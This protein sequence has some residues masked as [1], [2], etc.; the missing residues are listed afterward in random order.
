MKSKIKKS[1]YLRTAMVALAL[2]LPL[3]SL[4]PLGSLW[5][6]QKGYLLYWIVGALIISGSSFLLELWLV[7]GSRGTELMPISADAQPSSWTPRESAAWS[8]V[9]A[10]ATTTDPTLLGSR[11]AIL[12]LGLRTIE[13]V[14]RSIHPEADD[15]L[16]RF[17]VPEVLALIERV[18]RDLRP[19]IADNIPLGDQLTVGQVIRVYRWRGALDVAEKAY[20]LWRIVRLLNPVTAVAN[21]AR[22][23]LSKKL[24]TGV[25]DQVAQRLV[26]GYV[27][28]IGRA[29]IDL[30]GGR[31]RVSAND[32]AEHVTPA[33]Q[34]DQAVAHSAEPLRILIA[35]QSGAGKSSLINALSL[36]VNAAVDVLPTTV[37][38]TAYRLKPPA[39]DPLLLIDSPGITGDNESLRELVAAAD[40][41]DVLI[42]VVAANRADRDVDAKALDA[43][44]T[45]FKRTT[46]RR[47]PP[48]ITVVTHTDLLRPLRD[49]SQPS[50]LGSPV[51]Q[52]PTPIEAALNSIV[53]DL[54]LEGVALVPVCLRPEQ[55]ASSIANVWAAIN[56]IMPQAH[57]AKL[58]R[59]LRSAAPG[60]SWRK[61]WT[62]S[63]NAGTLIKGFK[64]KR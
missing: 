58:V 18:S 6:W 20:D 16:W 53:S 64:S 2:F 59:S 32:L 27:R 25:R 37:G 30:Y 55:S 50:K 15:P 41:S 28:E 39:L 21:E 22:E 8:A 12:D 38:F 3:L 36:N 51:S 57:A 35:G 23:R 48:L 26:E 54:N 10:L 1:G 11:E 9:D 42:W 61:L 19:F 60:W 13:T 56:A 49:W 29:A 5:L 40:T 52:Q 34:R 45:Y 63:Q 47:P 24:Y 44:R 7:R 62:Q 4:I 33:T 43:V 14:A 17:T 31:L 46:D